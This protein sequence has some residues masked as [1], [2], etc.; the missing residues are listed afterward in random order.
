MKKLI[1]LLIAFTIFGCN[2]SKEVSNHDV[3]DI[4][5]ELSV[6]NS[7]NEDLLD[8]ATANHYEAKKIKLFYEVDG[9]VKEVYLTGME[10]PR[11]FL[12]FKHENEYRIRIFMNSTET[13]DKPI[14]YIQWNEVDTDTIEATFEGSGANVRK[15]N[16]WFNGVE[17]WD[18]TSNEDGYFEVIK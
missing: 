9:E 5:F 17:V 4:G 15:R 3:Y 11:N 7:L 14:T 13:S 10:Y 6:F 18:W 2:K 8:T 16:V 12:I 1:F